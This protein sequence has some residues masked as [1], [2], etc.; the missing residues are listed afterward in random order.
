MNDLLLKERDPLP[1]HPRGCLSKYKMKSTI[2]APQNIYHERRDPTPVVVAF[3]LPS[4]P[5]SSPFRCPSTE[6]AQ[7]YRLQVSESKETPTP[8]MHGVNLV[9]AR[10]DPAVSPSPRAQ[11]LLRQGTQRPDLTPNAPSSSR[12]PPNAPFSSSESRL[13]PPSSLSQRLCR[14]PLPP[15]R[16]PESN[17]HRD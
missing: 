8:A 11:S 6:H 10:P 13:A 15:H 7:H 17:R 14:S 2:P 5:L 9:L 4:L 3:L 16:P 1:F 12:H